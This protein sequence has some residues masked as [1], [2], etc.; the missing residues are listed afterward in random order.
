MTLSYIARRCKTTLISGGIF[1]LKTI[2]IFP[3]ADK[4]IDF[5]GTRRVV[6][7]LG[8]KAQL[9]FDVSQIEQLRSAL[10]EALANKVGFVGVDEFTS[11]SE[12]VVVLG[13][14]GTILKAARRC[15][16]ANVPL[17]GINLGRVGYMA[18]LELDELELLDRLL[19]GEYRIEHR[20]LLEAEL[21]DG[22]RGFALNDAVLGGE[23]LF[24]MVEI[25]LFCDG[26]LVN[27]YRADGLIASTPT[28]STAY[29]LSAGGAVID[30]CMDAI[31][32]TP[33][34]THSL[35]AVSVVFS[36]ASKLGL[37]NASQ[38][39]SSLCLCLDGCEFYRLSY[40]E[41]VY[42]SR[43]PLGVGFIRLKD[44]GFYEVLRR[45][46]AENI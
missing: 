2:G 4:D 39:E 25:E 11:R 46:M 33:I 22:R 7:A 13:G 24:R 31:M 8:G 10:G 9:L 28:G 1:S 21:P 27:R 36:A 6:S 12:A 37:R 16:A 3:N 43:S 14:D 35:S 29:S 32:I 17:L 45:K 44:G 23:S 19:R 41:S 5:A 42:I 40:G 15:A 30:P 18:E 26:K 20:M 38:R 34:C